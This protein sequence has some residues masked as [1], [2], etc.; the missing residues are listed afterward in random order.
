MVSHFEVRRSDLNETRLTRLHDDRLRPG[1][2]R[3][4]IRQFALTANN[5]TY[6]VFGD[7]LRYWQFFP[8]D[9]GWGRIPVWGFADVE[10][11]NDS[12]L[13]TGERLYGF[14]PMSSH[15][16]IT[17]GNVSEIS[18]V[19]QASHRDELPAVYNRYSRC[20]HDPQYRVER[21]HE[22]MIFQPLFTTSYLIDRL[23]AEESN[24]LHCLVSSAS[25][26]TAIGLAWL[27]KRRDGVRPLTGLTSSSNIDFVRSL[28]IYDSVV[29]Y[30]DVSTKLKPQ[31]SLFVDIA[32]NSS[33][34]HQV[35][36]ALGSKLQRSLAVGASHWQDTEPTSQ[37][38]AGPKPQLFFAP[39]VYA[40][41]ASAIGPREFS[42]Q[43]GRDWLEFA[44][45][46]R[47]WLQPLPVIGMENFASA[48]VAIRAGEVNP[49]KSFILEN[50]YL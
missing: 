16:T 45:F 41:T 32:G 25:S 31:G 27:Q 37:V 9:E 40:S 48:F 14:L 34:R 44:D 12:A 29:A 33:V 1:E 8:T 47:A 20:T 23:L 30:E 2:A 10:D 22:Q 4:A 42:K 28:K 36:N 39:D 35:H 18:L 7:A 17:P 6:A 38:L 43:L 19:D 50:N 24:D 11:S 49:R 15:L 21:E 5:M 3:L 46:T 26:K 13:T